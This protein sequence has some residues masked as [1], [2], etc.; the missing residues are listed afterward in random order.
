MMSTLGHFEPV[1]GSG[2]TLSG[3]WCDIAGSAGRALYQLPATPT[4]LSVDVRE[5][6]T[7]SVTWAAVPGATSYK[8]Y[9]STV[10]GGPYGDPVDDDISALFYEDTGLS[11]SAEYYY[12]LEA[13]N[14][15]GCSGRSPEVSTTSTSAPSGG[16]G[17]GGVADVGACMVGGTYTAGQSCEWKGLDF[18]VMA[19]GTTSLGTFQIREIAIINNQILLQSPQ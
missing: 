15:D 8:L 7:I 9:R 10:S 5:G 4:I 18:V 1:D 13:C 14:F 6:G 16:G 11:E 17:G 2:Q 3:T 19:D 12:R